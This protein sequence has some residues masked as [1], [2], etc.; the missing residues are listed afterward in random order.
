MITAPFDGASR[1]TAGALRLTGPRTV[2]PVSV[3]VNGY[4]A[5]LY[6]HTLGGK[7]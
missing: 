2:N 1:P 6:E 7:V 3:D 4:L 5:G